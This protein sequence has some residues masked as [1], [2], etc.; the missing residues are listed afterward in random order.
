M[1]MVMLGEV[2]GE[3]V[4]RELAG[5]DDPMDDGELLK[6]G[7][8]PVD[9][10]HGQFGIEFAD[11]GNGERPVGSNEHVEESLAAAREPLV[12]PSEPRLD[13]SSEICVSAS[14]VPLVAIPVGSR[15]L[16]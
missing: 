1:M 7:E 13:A 5:R 3:F 10:T 9:R 4:V 12:G 11:L 6:C 14:G 16:R 2:F 15:T 8:V